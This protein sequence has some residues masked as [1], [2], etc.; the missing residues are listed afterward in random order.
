MESVAGGDHITGIN[1]TLKQKHP[2]SFFQVSPLRSVKT[3]HP[4]ELELYT[5]NHAAFRTKEKENT[6]TKMEDL[7][8]SPLHKARKKKLLSQKDPDA[9]SILPKK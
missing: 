7:N 8:N 6:I 9:H 3:E 5:E 4:N 2:K 1:G